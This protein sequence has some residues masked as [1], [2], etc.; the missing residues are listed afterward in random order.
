VSGIPASYLALYTSD[1][2]LIILYVYRF[3]ILVCLD[4]D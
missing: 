2:K 1:I 4:V 3:V